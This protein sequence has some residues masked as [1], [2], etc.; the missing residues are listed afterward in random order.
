MGSG[1]IIT[2]EKNLRWDTGDPVPGQSLGE[3][4]VAI[5]GPYSSS[6]PK[7]PRTPMAVTHYTRISVGP[8]CPALW[9]HESA[10]GQAESLVS[11]ITREGR[12]ELTPKAESEQ[13]EGNNRRHLHRQHTED[14]EGPL[15]AVHTTRGLHRPWASA[16]RPSGPGFWCGEK[17]IHTLKGKRASLGQTL[18]A[19]V[20]GTWDQ[21]LL[22]V[23][24]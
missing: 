12:S 20:A 22:P 23:E 19:S 5:V 7:H 2:R 14:S 1:A 21:N 6:T 16:L 11:G 9:L 8:N 18:K 15:S 10:G 17:G 4:P 13:T 24:Q 3:V